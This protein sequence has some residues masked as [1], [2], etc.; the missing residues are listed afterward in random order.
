MNNP[1]IEAATQIVL[2]LL[3]D[4]NPDQIDPKHLRTPFDFIC[5]VADDP[6]ELHTLSDGQA[7]LVKLARAIYNHTADFTIHD[8]GKF[9]PD[10]IRP[11]VKAIVMWLQAM[12]PDAVGVL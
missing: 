5:W 2:G 10:I 8:L 12:R 7:A 11:A 9:D 6:V 3:A 1:R 4:T